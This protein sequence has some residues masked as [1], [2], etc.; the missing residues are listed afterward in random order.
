MTTRARTAPETRVRVGAVV[1]LLLVLPAAAAPL[2][3]PTMPPTWVLVSAWLAVMVLVVT[4]TSLLA[5]HVAASWR[6]LWHDALLS[7]FTCAAG[8][9]ALLLPVLRQATGLSEPVAVLVLVKSAAAVVSLGTS[10]STLTHARRSGDRRVAWSVAAGVVAVAGQILWPLRLAVPALRTPE[11]SAVLGAAVLLG[12]LVVVIGLVRAPAPVACRRRTPPWG[13]DLVSVLSC[14]AVATGVL[15]AGAVY[16]VPGSA[17]LLAAAALVLLLSKVQLLVRELVALQ[18]SHEAAL[19]DE[20]TGLGNRRALVGQLDAALRRSD[21]VALLM[22]D[23]DGFK[24]VNDGLGHLAGDELLRQVAERLRRTSVPKAM[25]VRLGGDEF[26]VL[27]VEEAAMVAEQVGLGMHASLLEPFSVH[28]HRVHT[29]AS[30]GVAIRREASRLTS[31]DLLRRADTA[32]YAAKAARSGVVVHG[33]HHDRRAREVVQI[34]EELR[35]ALDAEQLL[36]HYQPQVSVTDGRL[37]GVEAL[38]RWNHPKR[39]LLSPAAFL[40]TAQELGLGERIT[41]LVLRQAVR[42]ASCWQAAGTPVR[43]SVNLTAADVQLALVDR[44]RELLADHDLPPHLL[45]LEITETSVVVDPVGAAAVLG[46]LVALG[47]EVSV[48]DF[49]TGHSSLTLLLQ[50]PV[51]EVKVDR[52]FVATVCDDPARRTVVRTTVELA[53]GLGMRVVAEGVEDDAV[54]AQLREL[55]CDTSQG[56]LHS[57][58]LPPAEFTAWMA[59]RLTGSPALAAG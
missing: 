49:G 41:D 55:G 29:T 14:G 6:S 48:D 10:L 34:A 38:V 36:L 53:H 24:H 15:V 33:A 11:V 25:L 52:S 45:A 28:S 37:V 9:L 22:L 4:Q 26:A 27:L 57:R 7:A 47:V 42:Q 5:Q 17:A 18:G 23:L 56:Y 40:D 54:L 50:L 35:L 51:A 30:I 39:G 16:D 20:L 43:V 2:W 59:S 1:A 13:K 21:T 44:V 8:L 32:M 46:E 31:E 12:W 58:P 19:T 3:T